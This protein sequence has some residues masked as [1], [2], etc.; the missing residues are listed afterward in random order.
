MITR[1]ISCRKDIEKSIT[2]LN[3]TI[4]RLINKNCI[5]NT[6][7]TLSND[8]VQNLIYLNQSSSRPLDSQLENIV[9][10]SAIR[11]ESMSAGS[12]E[13]FFYT[14]EYFIEKSKYKNTK[15]ERLEFLKEAK[16]EIV[17][18]SNE[19]SDYCYMIN[20]SDLNKIISKT[21]DSQEIR[22][23]IE[24]IVFKLS[25]VSQIVVEKTSLEKSILKKVSG[26][27][28]SIE[29]PQVGF[30]PNGKWDRTGVSAILVD[31]HIET[32]S[33]IHHFLDSISNNNG[34]A[35]I[36][37]RSA[38][39]EVKNTILYNSRRGSL[40]AVLI[41]IGYTVENNHLLNDIS[42]LFDCNVINIGM[43][44]TVSSNIDSKIFKIKRVILTQKDMTLFSDRKSEDIFNYI[45]DIKDLKDKLD[46]SNLDLESYNSVVDSIDSRVKF[47]NSKRYEIKIG[48]RDIELD[49]HAISKIDR[50]LRSFPDMSSMGIVK[51]ENPEK[52]SELTRAIFKKSTRKIFTQKQIITSF[53]TSYRTLET[54]IKAEK[55][56]TIDR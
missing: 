27:I 29:I 49:P 7:R 11:S 35:V 55:V 6:T 22:E 17:S 56:L 52:C 1:N 36:L 21:T 12:S 9:L 31:G 5:N 39:E 48:K 28:V 43:G 20:R 30:F 54:L 23:I 18:S 40:D 45:K 50:F 37:S 44:D 47:L 16:D 38:S 2:G 19:M 42:R 8:I 3:N 33:Q 4:S 34:R 10:S 32:V 14:L 13:I 26:N 53:I 15:K 25:P 41:E 51:I 46:M 24:K